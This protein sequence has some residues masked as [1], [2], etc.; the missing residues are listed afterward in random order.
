[1]ASFNRQQIRFELPA[2]DCERGLEYFNRGRVFSYHET[3]RAGMVT[4]S[5]VVRGTRPYSVNVLFP[6]KYAPGELSTSCS[7][8]RFDAMAH[9]KHVAAILYAYLDMDQHPE[10]HP[11]WIVKRE[12]RT[13]DAGRRLLDAMRSGFAPA[14]TDTAARVRVVP[15]I[16]T[17]EGYSKDFR[18]SLRIGT[19]RLY[20]VRDVS[21]FVQSVERREKHA[22]G[23]QLEFV[24]DRSAFAPE[25][26]PLVDYLCRA[27]RESRRAAQRVGL[28]PVFRDGFSLSADEFADQFDFFRSQSP[29]N[30]GGGSLEL[31]DGEPR[32]TLVA[33]R[34]QGLIVLALSVSPMP[35]QMVMGGGRVLF[36]YHNMIMRASEAF[37]SAVWP[38]LEDPDAA[39]IF[40]PADMTGFCSLVLPRIRDYVEIDDPEDILS[41]YTPE[42]CTPRFYLDMDYAL[43]CR[44][45]FHYDSADIPFETEVQGVR[46]DAQA[47]AEAR[48]LLERDFNYNERGEYF[49]QPDPTKAMNLLTGGMEEYRAIGE[50]YFS[51][52]L[53]AKQLRRPKAALGVSLSGGMMLLDADLGEFPPEELEDLYQSMLLRKKYHLLKNG[54]FMMIR[55]DGSG[56]EAVA[57]AAH[58]MQLPGEALK[59]GRAVLPAYRAP[60]LDELLKGKSDLRVKRDERFREMARRFKEVEDEE[61]PLP[62]GINAELRPYQEKGY[63]WMKTLQSC[64]FGGILADEMGLGK[65][66]QTIC[67]FA[68]LPRKDTG[69]AHLVVCPSSLVLNW[70]DELAKFAP[71]LGV[72]LI[73]GTQK[74][75]AMLAGSDHGE[76][77]WVTSYDL[78]KRDG[79]LYKTL[80]FHTCVLDEGQFVKNQSTKAS[81]AVKR[82]ACRQRFVLTGTPIENRLSELW[83]LFDFLMPGYLFSH[84]RFVEKLE[85]PIAQQGDREAQE[86][87]NRLVRPFLLRRLKKDVLKELPDKIE[88]VRRIQ[89]GDEARKVY[90]ALSAKALGELSADSGKLA[91]LAALTRLRQVCCDPALCFENYAGDSAKL[92]ACLELVQAMTEN[93]HQILLFSTFTSML[94]RIRARLSAMKITSFTLQ[95]DTP[96]EE[97]AR[98]VREFNHGGAQVFLISLKAGGTGL[99]LTAADV[100]IH[101]DPWWNIAAQNQATDR[102]HRIGQRNCVQVYKLIAEGTVEERI[103]ELQQ[104]KASLLDAVAGQ[105]GEGILELNAQELLD[106]MKPE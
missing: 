82:V 89:L 100:V 63:R 94:E 101:F 93:G 71:A 25:S 4:V 31:T 52:A 104:R 20:L 86:Q 14:Q 53:K 83:N 8:P 59:S 81:Q 75:R 37:S 68:S 80:Q 35:E 51:D 6:E 70:S 18:L 76:D 22:Y 97:R 48:R 39:F 38:L 62:E 96:R 85:R 99:N 33:A 2:L 27:V 57:E 1:M 21:A 34:R 98:L 61:F 47:E 10:K 105:A 90:T 17:P 12:A 43:C 11:D 54:R 45:V 16:H 56:I 91:I 92:E 65:T 58:M 32:V 69:L 106:L 41:S 24:H 7:C 15:M 44:L 72:K 74:E 60:Y 23:K 84:Q 3:H 49:V 103:L 66:L 28:L 73:I 87:L 36:C 102:A 26:L 77:V 79:E 95:G 30:G 55:G 42:T 64:G 5:G 9:C 29:Q 78:L 88:Y 67:Y 40:T 46:R 13:S 19:S 50:V